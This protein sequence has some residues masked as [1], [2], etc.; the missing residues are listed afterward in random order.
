MNAGTISGNSCIYT[1]GG[2]VQV[3]QGT[4]VM[5]GGTI[6]GN[7]AAE[8]GGGVYVMKGEDG[9]PSGTFTVGGSSVVSGNTVNGSANNVY[10]AVPLTIGSNLSLDANI[11]VTG[12]TAPTETVG[13]E[14]A[15]SGATDANKAAFVSDNDAYSVIRT[16]NKLYLYPHSHNWVYELDG[17]DTIKATCHASDCSSRNGDGGSVRLVVQNAHYTGA[18]IGATIEGSLTN[19]AVYKI[20]YNDGSET[21]PSSVG[22]HRATL[23]VTEN[24]VQKQSISI[25]YE[26]LSL[27]PHSHNWVY[28][29]D[30]SD[31]IKATCHASDCSSRNGD[32]GSVRLVVQNAHYTGAAIGATIEGSLT[33]GAVYKITY[34][35]G[36]ETA[37]SSVGKHRATLTVTE[38]G[39]QKQSVSIEYEILA[40]QESVP[41]L[42]PNQTISG[43]ANKSES[44]SVH[45][46]D[47]SNLWLWA[48]CLFIS[49]V[50]L[51]GMTLHKRK[52]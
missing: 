7:S 3:A 29:L 17:S 5:N 23:T 20:T 40:P 16:D 22:K 9:D 26:I 44:T 45:T 31:T 47:K 1:R 35:D 24:G 14:I 12:S 46:G 41:D 19:G 33:N 38:N 30:G 15:S 10:L 28:E 6:E 32:G 36:S 51:C 2:G 21:A 11:G 8:K 43:N 48:M 37:P 42:T 25:E 49:G 50:G 34:N 18:A 27:D 39:V 13:V 4:F 52:R